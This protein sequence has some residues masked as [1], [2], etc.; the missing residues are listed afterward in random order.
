MHHH[1]P[2]RKGRGGGRVILGSN[3][4]SLCSPCPTPPP[5]APLLHSMPENCEHSVTAALSW[6]RC[7]FNRSAVACF[8]NF[9]SS[10]FRECRFSMALFGALLWTASNRWQHT[11]LIGRH[12]VKALRK[13]DSTSL[14]GAMCT[15]ALTLEF[16]VFKLELDK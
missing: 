2:L 3:L 4:Q 14:N 5:G 10:F 13:S 1:R 16:H 9:I 12:K 7:V 6:S 8:V 11:F 15:A